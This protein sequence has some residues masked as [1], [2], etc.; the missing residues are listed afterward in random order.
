M[1]LDSNL[2]I[3]DFPRSDIGKCESLF[4]QLEPCTGLARGQQ[5]SWFGENVK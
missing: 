3:E 4:R 5:C 1:L 2:L